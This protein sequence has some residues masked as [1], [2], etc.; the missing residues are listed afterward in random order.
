M[1]NIV[2]I[3]VTSL[4]FTLYFAVSSPSRAARCEF[5]STKRMTAGDC[6]STRMP[7][8][9][10]RTGIHPAHPH[11]YHPHYPQRVAVES[12]S[13]MKSTPRCRMAR[14]SP[15]HIPAMA[16]T[17]SRCARSM[18]IRWVIY[19]K[20]YYN[21]WADVKVIKNYHEWSILISIILSIS[22]KYFLK[23]FLYAFIS[24]TK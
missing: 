9:R 21:F 2:L 23:T 15:R 18:A 6:S 5:C 16:A 12:S 7:C 20:M 11:P 19:C 17:S 10:W 13:K 4:F 14:F 22:L 3:E 1:T 24:N 8:K